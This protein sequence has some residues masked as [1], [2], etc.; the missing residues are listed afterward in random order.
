MVVIEIF[1]GRGKHDSTLQS[2]G[3]GLAGVHARRS[4]RKSKPR[5]FKVNPK[6]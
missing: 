2:V 4:R 3:A 1:E 6:T 5:P